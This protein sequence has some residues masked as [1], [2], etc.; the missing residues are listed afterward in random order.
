MQS[1]AKKVR[2]SASRCKRHI[3]REGIDE[4]SNRYFMEIGEP[5]EKR[6]RIPLNAALAD[7]PLE[8]R[9]REARKALYLTRYE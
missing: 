1:I 9:R 5:G 6:S 8:V 7:I 3:I 2:A 4:E